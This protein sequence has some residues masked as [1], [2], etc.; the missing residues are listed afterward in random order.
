MGEDEADRVLQLAAGV[1]GATER[2][3]RVGVGVGIGDVSES[4]EIEAPDVEAGV[5]QFIAPGAAVVLRRGGRASSSQ[6]P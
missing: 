1:L 5:V 2:G 3:I 6:M 4:V